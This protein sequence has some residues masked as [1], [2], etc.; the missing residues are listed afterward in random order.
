MARKK[1][2]GGGGGGSWLDTYADMVTLLL[3]FFIMLFS[4][5]TIQEEKWEKLLMAFQSNGTD[6]EQII[7]PSD[8]KTGDE[9]GQ[10]V[11]APPSGSGGETTEEGVNFE[12]LYEYLKEYVEQNNLSASVEV[13]QSEESV[14]IRFK[15]AIFFNPDSD[16]LR[17]DS[18]VILDFLG[19][20]LKQVED[21]LQLVYIAGHTAFVDG[22][23]PV[24]DWRLSGN[25]ATSVAIYLEDQ[26]GIEGKKLNAAGYGAKY[27]VDTNDTAEGRKNNRRVEMMILGEKATLTDP[28][29]MEYFLKGTYDQDIYP[30][31]GAA[32]DI[33]VP[34]G[35][36]KA[37]GE[38]ASTTETPPATTTSSTAT[39]P[40]A[41]SSAPA[42]STPEASKPT[43]SAP[44][45]SKPTSSAPIP[46]KPTSSASPPA[47]S[48]T[49]S[50]RPTTSANED[51]LL[52]PPKK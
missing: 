10:N 15:D 11:G 28:Q 29:I 8:Q 25:R 35:A 13:S 17:K 9:S 49:T 27:P 45:P 50:S 14:Y 1:S 3:T 5:S 48:N 47:T 26:A 40:P 37:E 44:I 42:Q 6:T 18:K 46:S 4:M 30:A 16:Y 22:D 39:P 2:G 34:E 51:D 52:S 32:T 38:T 41:T 31:E 7:V 33:L 19:D 12:T 20:A 36:Q 43:S 24:S 23:Y 21:Q